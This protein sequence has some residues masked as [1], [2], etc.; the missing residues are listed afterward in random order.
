[1]AHTDR[2]HPST[3]RHKVRVVLVIPVLNPGP[4]AATLVDAIAAQTRRP[5]SVL[6]LDSESNDGWIDEFTRLGALIHPVKRREFDHGGTR[7]LAFS[8]VDG[9]IYLF[10]TQDARPDS[11]DAF[12]RLLDAFDDPGVGVA[13]GRQLPN[14]D[15]TPFAAHARLFNYP[16]AAARRTAADIPTLGI[17]AAFCSNSFAAYRREALAGVGGFPVNQLFGEDTFAT[18]KMLRL[19]WT[20]AYVADA[21]VEHS[22]NYSHVEEF[23]RYF[24]TGAVHE[25]EAWYIAMLGGA[26]G[27]GMRFVRSELAYVRDAG[28]AFGTIRTVARNAVRWLGYRLGR[29]HRALPRWLVLRCAMHPNFFRRR[30]AAPAPVVTT[31]ELA[32]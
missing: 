24:D 32:T 21:A 9:D 1:V 23:R 17:K 14:G 27:E 13:Y 16:P 7:N 22:H 15:A 5:D 11:R 30:F 20:V 6:V 31:R 12:A 26:S 29:A 28:M 8:L 2:L 3:A 19:R 4:A 10:L 25:I 18:A